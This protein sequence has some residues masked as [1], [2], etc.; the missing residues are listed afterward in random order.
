MVDIV[1]RMVDI[2][3]FANSPQREKKLKIAKLLLVM[4]F[5]IAVA[6]CGGGGSGG[7]STAAAIS[8]TANT[9]ARHLT[10]GTAMTVFSPLTASGGA[11]PYT[12]SYTGTLP[13]GLSF[14]TSTGTVTGTPTAPYATAN[15][16]FS[17]RDANNNYANTTSTVSF[18]VSGLPAGYVVQ[19][20]LTW[21][22]VTFF[23]TWASANAYCANTAINGQTGWRMPT[24][25]ELSAL[26]TSG[27]MNGQE[28]ALLFTWSS[29]VYSTVSVSRH[30]YVELGN[31]SVGWSSDTDL[32]YV[33][34]VR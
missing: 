9:T 12:Y 8:A 15:L 30:Y 5:S 14:N 24:Q 33:S 27:A 34:C 25:T 6:A 18:T 20:G 11:T 31:G 28:W 23:D 4:L 19:G 2:A 13:T 22:P 1:N 10:V 26:Y 17:V 16:I 29:T 21:M 3:P 32:L 7:G